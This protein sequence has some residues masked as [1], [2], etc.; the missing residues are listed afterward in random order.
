MAAQ[1]ASPQDA[2]HH[3]QGSSGNAK[4]NKNPLPG[5]KTDAASRRKH[6]PGAGSLPPAGPEFLAQLPFSIRD[7][8]RIAR[9]GKRKH[10]YPA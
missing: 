5:L 7:H 6:P 4:D 1:P 10:Q 9:K 8:N 3:H 2:Q